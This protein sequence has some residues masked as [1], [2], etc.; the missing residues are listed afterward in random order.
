M[1]HMRKWIAALVALCLLTGALGALGE[2]N[3][4]NDLLGFYQ[5]ATGQV[6]AVEQVEATSQA[7]PTEQAEATSQAE[8]TEQ[9]EATSQA[10][11]AA[12]EFIPGG[13]A[14]A[15][16]EEIVPPE[17][18]MTVE[19]LAINQG[20]PGEWMN[21]LLLGTDSRTTQNYTRT[22]TM[23]VL[24][25][26][27]TAGL[28]KLTSL[29]RDLWVDI[30]GHGGAKLNAAC[31]YGG[32]A[33]TMRCINENFG[34]NI[35][36]YVLVN[37]QCL[38]TIVDSL[39]GIPMD[40][41]DS[42][43]SAINKLFESDL[44]AN[45]ENTYFVGDAVSA[46]TQVLLNGKQ[47]LAFARIRSLDSDYARTDRQR[48]VLITIAKRMQQLDLVSL[49]AILMNMLQ[50]VETN[51]TFDDIM[52]LASACM[53][54]NLDG[55]T[56]LRLPAEGTYQ[57]GTFGGTWCIKADFAANTELLHQFIYENGVN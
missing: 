1:R 16:E 34:L 36:T 41:T 42:E 18:L 48:R 2:E 35:D 15:E 31:V 23:I 10:E 50:Y 21:I 6:E 52:A 5:R 43:A 27:P 26:N 38:A 30:P 14:P 49:G 39:G 33:L 3:R 32:P 12:D 55:V 56:D 40:V 8:P 24:S 25:V 19:D 28:V 37:M 7:E 53:N 45:D 4:M 51:L 13:E 17:Q 44:N 57:S 22:D 29:M 11:P 54:A 9:V 20:L 47:A 46:G